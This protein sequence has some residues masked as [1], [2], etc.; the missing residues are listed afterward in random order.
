MTTLKKHGE[1]ARPLSR[2]EKF[3][4]LVFLLLLVF[5]ILYGMYLGAWSL[6]QE[7]EVWPENSLNA[8]LY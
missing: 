7:E 5:A 3:Q 2:R 8:L 4:V 1:Y 6:Q